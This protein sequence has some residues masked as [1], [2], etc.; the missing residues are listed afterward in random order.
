MIFVGSPIRR[1]IVAGLLYLVVGIA[2]GI[3]VGIRSS[4]DSYKSFYIFAG[5]GAFLSTFLLWLILIEKARNKLEGVVVGIFT[6]VISHY[7][8]WYLLLLVFNIEYWVLG[9]KGGTLEPP[10]D[11]LNA[12]WAV[13]VYCLWS[14]IFFGWITIPAGMII[15]W[16]Y[17]W[18]LN[19]K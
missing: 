10:I 1:S 15:C 6:G 11:P 5:L 12:I 19:R 4:N 2:V 13:I 16:L 9:N 18:F 17:A 7:F 14:L 3:F 8:C